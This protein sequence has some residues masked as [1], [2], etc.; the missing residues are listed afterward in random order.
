MPDLGADKFRYN[1]QTPILLS[2][3]NQDILYMA[4]NVF[5]RSM[6]KGQ[7]MKPLSGDLT[8]G[9]KA[10]DLTYGTVVSLTES[11]L[12]FGVIYAGTDD[13]NIQ[14]S[15][16]GGY[17]WTLV[18]A[19]LP[20]GLYVS[21][22][23]ASAFKEGRVYA[24]LNGYRN[25]SFTPW[26]YVS[27]DFGQTWNKLG[28]DLP[29]GPLNVVREDPNYED[30]LYVGSDNGLYASLNRGKSFMPIGIDL[31][32]VPVHDIAIQKKANDIVIATHGRSIYIASLD[33]VQKL[34]KEA[35]KK[36]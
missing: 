2:T 16:D 1:W 5:F 14:L 11:P 9:G 28:N 19:K 15:K 8:N 7:N 17:T 22:V 27:E 25:D 18:S 4:S 6:D 30:I 10:G 20:K 35:A 29:E 23:V 12:K 21:R 31:P 13:G 32:S 36:N 24:T 34:Y 33:D 26:V 3:F